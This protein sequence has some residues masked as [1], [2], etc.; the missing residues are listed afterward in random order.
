MTTSQINQLIENAFKQKLDHVEAFKFICDFL[1][2]DPILE[3]TVSQW[4][5]A[6]FESEQLK[7]KNPKIE[8]KYLTLMKEVDKKYFSFI[9]E[10]VI[11]K[12]KSGRNTG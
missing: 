10:L 2:Y 11:E 12:Y 4:F 7:C 9:Y 6:C 3:T 8:Q 1:N 5:D